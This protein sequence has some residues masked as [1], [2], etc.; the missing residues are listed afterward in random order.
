[1][2]VFGWDMDRLGNQYWLIENSFGEEWGTNGLA[3]VKIGAH[4]STLDKVAVAVTPAAE[5]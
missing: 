4:D 1:M 3:K 5:E 2:K